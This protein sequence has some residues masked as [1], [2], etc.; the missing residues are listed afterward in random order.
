MLTQNGVKLSRQLLTKK[1][2][3]LKLFSE[4]V[5]LEKSGYQLS[6][7][8]H[9]VPYSYFPVLGHRRCYFG[10]FSNS[11]VNRHT[12]T[13][14][15]AKKIRIT[16]DFSHPN[17]QMSRVEIK[18]IC[19]LENPSSICNIAKMLNPYSFLYGMNTVIHKG[20]NCKRPNLVPRIKDQ[21]I[22]QS[23]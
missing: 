5:L 15:R 3:H 22:C 12:K 20:E 21:C 6:T 11:P 7:Q 18:L 14:I 10:D 9:W 13:D 16:D 23:L 4:K 1:E 17:S 2:K 19:L 8:L